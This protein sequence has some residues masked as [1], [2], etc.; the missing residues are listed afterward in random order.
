MAKGLTYLFG[1]M[2]CANTALAQTDKK[3][4]ELPRG[5]S[6][7]EY[8]LT[9]KGMPAERLGYEGVRDEIVDVA[10]SCEYYFEKFDLG[11][12]LSRKKI[13]GLKSKLLIAYGSWYDAIRA[14][15]LKIDREKF[16]QY[17]DL[18]NPLRYSFNV[19]ELLLINADAPQAEI[20]NLKYFENKFRSF[21]K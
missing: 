1:A 5:E 3:S 21:L 8:I 2:L 20:D 13:L 18:I 9:S 17:S 11:C 19:T 6:G 16:K 4:E 10:H 15:G 12:G 14:D 7:I